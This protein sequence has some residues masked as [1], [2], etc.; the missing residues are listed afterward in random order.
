MAYQSQSYTKPIAFTSLGLPSVQCIP[1]SSSQSH[2]R[3][4]G[5]RCLG[6]PKDRDPTLEA[7]FAHPVQPRWKK[8]HRP[9]YPGQALSLFKSCYL[10]HTQMI[11][12]GTLAFT[13]ATRKE[14]WSLDLR[15]SRPEL[16][17]VA[18]LRNQSSH[19]MSVPTDA[20]SI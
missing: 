1:A 4:S 7:T 5:R 11:P 3:T 14:F 8:E 13:G 15:I 12:N 2:P 17:S 16:M 10:K 19:P 6:V 20:S 9:V 18:S